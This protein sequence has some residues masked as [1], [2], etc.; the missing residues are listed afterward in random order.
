M[1]KVRV[2]WQG[3]EEHKAVLRNLPETMT[4]TAARLALSTANSAVVEIRPE[5][6]VKTGKLRDSVQITEINRGPYRTGRQVRVTSPLANIFEGEHKPRKTKAGW[7]RGTISTPSHI[8]I[9]RI[10]K[11]RRRFTELLSI[12]LLRAGASRVTQR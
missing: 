4:A 12:A 2:V 1:A 11:W 9:P 7:N 8:F 10:I 5:Y 3:L 6:P